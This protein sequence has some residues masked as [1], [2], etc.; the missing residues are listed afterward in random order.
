M[1]VEEIREK[2]LT[3]DVF[4]LAEVEKVQYL[5]GLQS[6]IRSN[7]QRTEDIK[8]ESV[9]EHIYA[10]D[11]LAEYFS[12]IEEVS[13]LD[14]AKVHAMITWHD[15]DEIETGDTPGFLKTDDHRKAESEAIKMAIANSPIALQLQIETISKEYKA[16]ETVE[17]RFVKALDKIEPVFYLLNPNGKRIF[18]VSPATKEQH[19]RIKEPYVKGFPYMYRFYTVTL[20]V[21]EKE[22][23]F[24]T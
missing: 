11:V 5:Y 13:E 9:A 1:T 15:I 24:T 7:L 21:F 20:D 16:Q 22:N 2:I 12:V 6:V 18:E 17:A 23:Y 10:L 14:M 3:D 8:T 4:V 19:C